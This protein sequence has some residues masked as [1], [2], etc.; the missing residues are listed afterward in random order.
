[1]EPL[2]V[3]PAMPWEPSP[4]IPGGAAP[5]IEWRGDWKAATKATNKGWQAEMAISF[6]ILR[7]P[8]GQKR[9]GIR[10]DR[11]LPQPRAIFGNRAGAGYRFFNL[12]QGFM[13]WYLLTSR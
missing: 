2:T 9:F 8:R 12:A 5:K 3:L 10:F 7:V 11:Y 1:M 6:R 13:L 4:K